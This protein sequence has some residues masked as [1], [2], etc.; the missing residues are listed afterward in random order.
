M[1]MFMKEGYGEF[2]VGRPKLRERGR[3]TLGRGPRSVGVWGDSGQWGV[4]AARPG[5]LMDLVAGNQQPEARWW[6]RFWDPSLRV[7]C[8]E[9]EGRKR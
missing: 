9:K 1:F 7:R 6:E 4:G 8:L 2:A 3:M 5:Y